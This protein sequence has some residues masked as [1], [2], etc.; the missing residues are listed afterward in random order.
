MA[1]TPSP[2]ATSPVCLDQ[3]P[4]H[5]PVVPAVVRRGHASR[6]TS[7]PPETLRAVTPIAL[8]GQSARHRSASAE[9]SPANVSGHGP[10]RTADYILSPFFFRVRTPSPQTPRCMGIQDKNSGSRW[11]RHAF[12]RHPLKNPN[13][14]VRRLD[15][16]RDRVLPFAC[17]HEVGRRTTKGTKDTKWTESRYLC[18]L[19]VKTS[20]CFG[21]GYAGSGLIPR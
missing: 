6:R 3:Q 7:L 10:M 17:G 5:P 13:P 18:V 11:F 1:R 20:W 4:R 21:S 16:G 12:A 2:L 14:R 9:L 8:E 19:V 15:A